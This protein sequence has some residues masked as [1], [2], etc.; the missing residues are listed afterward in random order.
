MP[1][2]VCTKKVGLTYSCP[3]NLNAHPFDVGWPL[4][5]VKPD[6]EVMILRDMFNTWPAVKDF[7]VGKE[8]HVP[9]E[10]GVVVSHYHFYLEFEKK[11]DTRNVSYFDF[12]GVHPNIKHSINSGWAAYCAK[13]DNYVTNFYKQ[14][15]WRQV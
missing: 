4:G 2:R 9:R 15:P 5:H 10:D 12:L 11:L 8:T 14:D 1:F 6:E 3:V 13:E 7:I